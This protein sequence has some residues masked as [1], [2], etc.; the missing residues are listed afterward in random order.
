MK[1]TRAFAA[2]LCFI[3]LSLVS[4][5]AEDKI[6]KPRGSEVIIVARIQISPA[7]N[8]DFFSHY[9]SFETPSTK[10]SVSRSVRKG[11]IPN[12]TLALFTKDQYPKMRF[13]NVM[14][15]SGYSS[16]AFG[17]LGD[18]SLAKFSIPKN[19]EIEIG[20]VRVYVVDNGFLFF[21]VPIN[22][23]IVIPEGV[24]YVYLGTI[25]CTMANEYFEISDISISDE[26]DGAQAYVAK[27]FGAQ[28][29]LVR[30]NLLAVD[31]AKK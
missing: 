2:F 28:A 21:D 1:R 4:G 31:K 10:V 18:V 16:T 12:D 7:P 19:R 30:V 26:F 5:F 14:D 27:T 8:R 15:F 6:S 23:K 9:A 13:G 24:N 17:N 29:Q 3:A 20:Y 25:A 11:D 22:R